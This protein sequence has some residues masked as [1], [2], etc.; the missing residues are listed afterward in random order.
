M[1]RSAPRRDTL[2]E[3]QG[4]AC[5][6]SQC[7]S[8]AARASSRCSL[9][10]TC[11]SRFR[12]RTWC[13][14]PLPRV[15]HR[16]GGRV[17]AAALAAC[18]Y[19]CQGLHPSCAPQV[20]GVQSAPVAWPREFLCGAEHVRWNLQDPLK[21]VVAAVAEHVGGA[22]PMHRGRAPPH[23]GAQ[24]D[25][26]WATGSHA[27]ASTSLSARV[28][29]VRARSR[30]G[31]PSCPQCWGSIMSMPSSPELTAACVRPP[32]P[33]PAVHDR[34]RPPQLPP[35]VPRRLDRRL[36]RR[37]GAAVGA[38]ERGPVGVG[39]LRGGEGDRG[40]GEGARGGVGGRYGR[41]TGRR[42]V[43]YS[44]GDRKPELLWRDGVTFS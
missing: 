13:G 17:A 14:P 9:G 39:G 10:R 43:Q 6:T 23:G 21:A 19:A 12:S 31:S 8:S 25:W 38:D 29:R 11:P 37:R 35:L 44:R 5:W 1:R 26:L 4:T 42:R 18:V 33:P 40:G 28:S 20:I 7:S 2:R 3:A 36:Q 16:R 34:R 32:P 27:L 15:P 24:D 41:G 22:L 30:R